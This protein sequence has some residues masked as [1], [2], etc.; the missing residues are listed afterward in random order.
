VVADALSR[1]SHCNHLLEQS[2]TSCCDPEE[3]NLW[4]IPHGR[5]NNIALTLTIKENVIVTQ[6]MDV[7]M[8]YIQRRL[9]LGEVKCFREDA[10]GVI[11]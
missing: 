5:W 7:G 4:V 3:Q 10:N 1:K 9:E 11:W 8:G 2:L 6:K